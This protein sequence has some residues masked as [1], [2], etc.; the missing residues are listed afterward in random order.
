[1][2]GPLVSV[3]I[4]TYNNGEYIRQAVDSVY[5]QQVYL[6]L[7]V[8]DDCSDDDTEKQLECYMQRPDFFYVRNSFNRGVAASRNKGVSMARGEYIAFLDADD[9]WA[10]GKLREQIQAVKESGAVLCSTGRELMEPDGSSTGR[11]IGVRKWVTY[12]ELLKH[13]SINCSSVFLL[14]KVAREFPMCYDQSHEDYI[15]WLK[16]LKKYGWARGIDRPYLKCRLSAGGKSRDKL[17]SAKMTFQVYRYMGYGMV[18]SCL[19]FI[20]YAVHGVCKYR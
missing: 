11:Y 15:T 20:S 4:P 5:R 8:V 3:V 10:E 7:I 14:T 18:K 9:W 19:F 6:E 12:R 13:N 16:I 1:M 2:N 17:K